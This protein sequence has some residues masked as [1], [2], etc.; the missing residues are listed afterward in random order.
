MIQRAERSGQ[1]AIDARKVPGFAEQVGNLAQE[2]QERYYDRAA[3]QQLLREEEEAYRK[4]QQSL[5]QQQTPRTDCTLGS[6]QEQHRQVE[7]QTFKNISSPIR[8]R[9]TGSP[10]ARMT[11]AGSTTGGAENIRK[12]EGRMP[13]YSEEAARSPRLN[14]LVDHPENKA[15]AARA[16]KT[17]ARRVHNKQSQLPGEDTI[18]QRVRARRRC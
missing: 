14:N 1:V 2:M 11:A 18:A 8:Q 3:Q 15:P 7:Q 17:P 5:K 12:N 10:V 4:L 6:H 9:S 13:L 16:P